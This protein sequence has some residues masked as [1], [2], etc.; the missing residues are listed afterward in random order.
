[1][2]STCVVRSSIAGPNRL[3]YFWR[4]F[5]LYSSFLLTLSLSRTLV[6]SVCPNFKWPCYLESVQSC[7]WWHHQRM[8]HRRQILHLG[9]NIGRFTV[10]N[11]QTRNAWKSHGPSFLGTEGVKAASH[12]QDSYGGCTVNGIA[13]S[14]WSVPRFITTWSSATAKSMSGRSQ[15]LYEKCRCDRHSTLDL[16]MDEAIKKCLKCSVAQLSQLETSVTQFR[17][18]L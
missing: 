3:S 4:Y 7:Y 16:S 10:R 12:I 5:T 17:L 15:K 1:M 2:A 13:L 9:H 8:F 18:F 6:R 14:I 11:D